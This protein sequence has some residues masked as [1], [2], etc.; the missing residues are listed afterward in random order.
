MR[1]ID[2]KMNKFYHWPR[3]GYLRFNI[4]PVTQ[5]F[6]KNH[7]GF[8]GVFKL[9]TDQDIKT[10]FILLCLRDNIDRLFETNRQKVE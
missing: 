2:K 1:R 6:N 9:F 3:H 7:D 8:K 4:W 5:Q 10:T